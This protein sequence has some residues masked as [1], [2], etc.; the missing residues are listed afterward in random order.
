MRR[1]DYAGRLCVLGG[2]VALVAIAASVMNLGDAA[3][4]G[5]LF[6]PADDRRWALAI[7]LAAGAVGGR[8]AGVDLGW[9]FEQAAAQF[10]QHAAG[11]LK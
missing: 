5:E 8:G 3:N 2:C 1:P 11:S 6:G 10:V 7:P 9:W 4:V